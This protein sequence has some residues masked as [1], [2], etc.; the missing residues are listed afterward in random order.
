LRES[1]RE[2]AKVSKYKK[3]KEVD[4]I[5]QRVLNASVV[6]TSEPGEERGLEGQSAGEAQSKTP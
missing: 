5:R 2:R 6:R 1:R 3:K 4:E